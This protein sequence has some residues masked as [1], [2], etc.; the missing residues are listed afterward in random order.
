MRRGFPAF[1]RIELPVVIA[2]IAL[3]AN[4]LLPAP[5]RAK[6][7]AGSVVGRGNLRWWGLA[8]AM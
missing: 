7:A 2:I 3:L 1:N 6:R 5:G 8:W 4:L